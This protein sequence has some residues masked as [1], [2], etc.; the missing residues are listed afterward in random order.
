M[1]VRRVQSPWGLGRLETRLEEVKLNR[2]GRDGWYLV[3]VYSAK[4]DS[5][6]FRALIH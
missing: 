4:H 6:R 3:I 1:W 5:P 2:S